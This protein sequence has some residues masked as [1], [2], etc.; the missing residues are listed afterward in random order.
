MYTT[1]ELQLPTGSTC[2]QVMWPRHCEQHSTGA[3]FHVELHM[4][5]SDIIVSKGIRPEV[6]SYSGFFDNCHISETIMR[7]L[8]F[9]TGVSQIYVV[10]LPY[11]L[12]DDVSIILPWGMPAML[13]V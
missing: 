4:E 9:E 11:S 8:M 1:K 10:G 5:Q 13:T 6:D 2:E 12:M 7:R 3:K